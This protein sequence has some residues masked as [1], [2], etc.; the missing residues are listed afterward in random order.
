MEPRKYFMNEKDNSYAILHVMKQNDSDIQLFEYK[1]ILMIPKIPSTFFWIICDKLYIFADDSWYLLFA[2][3]GFGE[4][5]DEIE[6]EVTVTSRIAEFIFCRLIKIM[7]RT[8]WI[9]I[10]KTAVGHY[11]TMN[12]YTP[13]NSSKPNVDSISNVQFYWKTILIW[14]IM[15]S[16][17]FHFRNRKIFNFQL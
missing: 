10:L 12:I 16:I 9:R 4:K 1:I 14:I 11:L 7:L 13:H 3:T 5:I 6:E 15:Y 2:H 8:N 17:P